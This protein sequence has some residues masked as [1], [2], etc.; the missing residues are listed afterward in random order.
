MMYLIGVKS[1]ISI[2]MLVS[3]D[4]I[5]LNIEP[6]L[7]SP[8]RFK[9][10]PVFPYANPEANNGTSCSTQYSYV[11]IVGMVWLIVHLIYNFTPKINFIETT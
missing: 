6:A 8:N 7:Q 11:D 3:R 9:S 4:I 1:A 5:L 10:L 2:L